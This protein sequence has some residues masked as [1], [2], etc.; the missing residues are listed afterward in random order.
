MRQEL[1]AYL[2]QSDG[3]IVALPTT[4]LLAALDHV[5]AGNSTQRYHP[6]SNTEAVS[7]FLQTLKAVMQTCKTLPPER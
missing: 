1:V 7:A 2:I 5:R 6:S 4:D 3:P